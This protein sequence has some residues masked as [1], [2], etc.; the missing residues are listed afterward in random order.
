MSETTGEGSRYSR[1]TGQL[2]VFVSPVIV[3]VF[4]ETRC[5]VSSF[6]SSYTDGRCKLLRWWSLS[7]G[8]CLVQSNTHQ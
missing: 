8:V 6:E 1:V 2:F 3:S 7:S 5:L 4:D